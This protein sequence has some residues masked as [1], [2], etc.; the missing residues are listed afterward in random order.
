MKKYPFVA[1]LLAVILFLSAASYAVVEYTGGTYVQNFDGLA[2][3]GKNIQFEND[4]TLPSWFVLS[5][6][7]RVVC[8]GKEDFSFAVPKRENKVSGLYSAGAGG[9]KAGGMYSFGRQKTNPETDRALGAISFGD[10]ADFF[11]GLCLKN[12]SGAELPGFTLSYDGEQWRN[13]GGAGQK[14]MVF[15]RIGGEK[16]DSTG[17]WTRLDELT[18]TSPQT[19]GSKALDG[20]AAANRAVLSET[21]NVA[22]PAGENIWVV[23]VDLDYEGVDDHALAIDNVQFAAVNK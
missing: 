20:N 8:S 9:G 3:S 12:A 21:V 4:S 14:M 16:F 17:I 6:D 11:Y 1:T 23:W 2:S 7:A 19:G 22:V 18:F 15:Y 10:R 13:F 5:G